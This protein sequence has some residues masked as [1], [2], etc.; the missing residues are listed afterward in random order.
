MKN[1]F[2]GTHHAGF[3]F[4]LILDLWGVSFYTV[5]VFGVGEDLLSNLFWGTVILYSLRCGF[6]QVQGPFS[7]LHPVAS[8]SGF[9]LPK[10]AENRFNTVH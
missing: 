5:V 9:K 4:L 6:L 1:L 7:M 2:S 3:Q 10:P 8:H